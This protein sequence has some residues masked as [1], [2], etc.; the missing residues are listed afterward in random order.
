MLYPYQNPQIITYSNLLNKS[1]FNLTQKYLLNSSN[2]SKDLYY[3]NFVLVS[4]GN[5]KDPI[6][7]Y[8]NLAAQSLWGITWDDFVQMPSRLTVMP[9]SVDERQQLL[10]RASKMGYVDNY[11]GIRVTKDGK[12]FLIDNTILW[13]VVDENGINH[14][15]AAAIYTWKML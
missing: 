1:Y 12:K 10:N 4:H 5:Q 6:F 15:Q 9:D 14:G 2:I 8:A 3:A 7:C 11:R 13:N